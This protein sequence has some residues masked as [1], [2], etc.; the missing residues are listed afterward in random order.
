MASVVPT[1]RPIFRLKSEINDSVPVIWREVH[2]RPDMRLSVLHQV[3][4]V[5]FNWWDYHLYRFTLHGR[6][7]F[8]S[9]AEHVLCPFDVNEPEDGFEGKAADD[10]LLSEVLHQ[11][12]DLLAYLYDYGD[13]W[14]LT[15]TLVDILDSGDDEDGEAAEAV[16]VAG[17]RA[18]PPE[19]CGGCRTSDELAEILDDPAD[20]SIEQVNDGMSVVGWWMK[21]AADPGYPETLARGFPLFERLMRDLGS[22]PWTVFLGAHLEVLALPEDKL[23]Y[24]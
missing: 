20:F 2:V 7:A 4:Q 5:T 23:P 16:C 21:V 12:G 6:D 9:A 22:S 1:D 11:P 15:I 18:A 8:D 14:D 17:E 13:N 3:I 24:P 10:V 19:D